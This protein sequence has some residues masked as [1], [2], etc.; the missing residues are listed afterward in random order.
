MDITSIAKDLF[1]DIKI[2]LC[3]HYLLKLGFYTKMWIQNIAYR[4]VQN[5]THMD[6]GP[7]CMMINI[8]DPAHEYPVPKYQCTELHRFEFLDLENA[9]DMP[10]AVEFMITDVQA[11][12]LVALL[13][14]A[15]NKSMNV[16]VSCHAGICRSGAVAEVGVMMGF[17]DAKA[18]RAPNLR[19]KHKMLRALGWTYDADEAPTNNWQAY[20]DYLESRGDI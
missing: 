15:L 12:Q 3:Y 17:E 8:V 5:G 1:L 6:P 14:R 16:I 20:Y 2:I 11:A 7:N 18:F 13:Q 4:D 9:D 19:V 10:D